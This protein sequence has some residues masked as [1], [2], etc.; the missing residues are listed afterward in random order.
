MSL[1]STLD[2][3]FY[4]QK[5]FKKND[6]S[7]KILSWNL[8]TPSVARIRTQLD[9]I[10]GTN[11]DILVLTELKMGKSLDVLLYELSEHDYK[12]HFSDSVESKD[13]ITIVATRGVESKISRYHDI[14]ISLI[15]NLGCY[16]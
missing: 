15:L 11:S 12:C 14:T 5:P 2:L 1:N 6:C 3:G 16:W 8:Q 7:L 10:F 4:S 13:Y 9:Y